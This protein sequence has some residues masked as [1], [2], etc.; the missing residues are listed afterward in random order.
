VSEKRGRD[1]SYVQ[2]EKLGEPLVIPSQNEKKARKLHR[3]IRERKKKREWL[4]RF[5]CTTDGGIAQEKGKKI[6]HLVTLSEGVSEKG[7]P[8]SKKGGRG[9][10]PP[11][12]PSR[13]RHSPSREKEKGK[14]EG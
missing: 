14:K 10:L 12:T 6:P 8:F 1:E 7:S 5:Y 2:G 11:P 3:L 4:F 13:K 9:A